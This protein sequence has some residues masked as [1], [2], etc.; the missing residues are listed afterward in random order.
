MAPALVSEPAAAVPESIHASDPSAAAALA[1]KPVDK[2]SVCPSPDIASV[3]PDPVK[4]FQALPSGPA[5]PT[6]LT[7][8]PAALTAPT[9]GDANTLPMALVIGDAANF[10]SGTATL[11]LM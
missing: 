2:P 5:T 6:P 1:L 10:T 8:P 11:A 3:V 4:V 7:I 9:P